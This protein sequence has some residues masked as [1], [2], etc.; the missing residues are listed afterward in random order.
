MKSILR[1]PWLIN[2]VK[3]SCLVKHSDNSV[4]RI[5]QTSPKSLVVLTKDTINHFIWNPTGSK[6]D[7]IQGRLALFEKK[8]GHR[9]TDN[10]TSTTSTLDLLSQM[11]EG[12]GRQVLEKKQ[13]DVPVQSKIT[14]KKK[15]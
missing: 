1:R 6:V 5:K 8:Y 10:S 7:D 13:V 2:P 14:N 3:L 15:K 9:D 4:F 11:A 12:K